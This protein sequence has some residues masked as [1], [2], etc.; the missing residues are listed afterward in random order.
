LLFPKANCEQ[1]RLRDEIDQRIGQV[2]DDARFKAEILRE[3]NLSEAKFNKVLQSIVEQYEPFIPL[4][5]MLPQ[6]R[7]RY[8]LGIINNGTYLTH[9]FFEQKYHFSQ[10]FDGF[11]SSAI[12]GAC[13]PGRE[14]Y[15]RACKILGSPPQNC[16]FL[17]DSLE[18]ITGAQEVGMQTI[19]W[20]DRESG[21]QTFCGQI[22]VLNVV[23]S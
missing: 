10:E 17:D 22:R 9:P 19:H 20:P 15:L 18:N 2:S 12:E 1:N 6:L 3:Y 5:K 13:K 8:K 16:L 23:K 4:W 7:K 11:I 21:F 14:I